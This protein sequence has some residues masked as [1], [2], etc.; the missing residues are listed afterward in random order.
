MEREDILYLIPIIGGIVAYKRYKAWLKTFV[1]T[2]EELEKMWKS[3][4]RWYPFAIDEKL[5]KLELRSAALGI[6]ALELIRFAF[7]GLSTPIVY[8]EYAEIP[9]W[10]YR[11]EKFA[12]KV[13]K[14]NPQESDE[15]IRLRFFGIKSLPMEM[16]QKTKDE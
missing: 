1:R 7:L 14:I 10:P 8:D 9:L 15:N 16:P 12:K 3:E 11:M 13:R 2:E 4:G 5:Y 6:I